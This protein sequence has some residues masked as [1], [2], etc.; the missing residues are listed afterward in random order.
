MKAIW[1]NQIIA[2]SND[3]NVQKTN[4]TGRIAFLKGVKIKE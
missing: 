4:I 1:N 2:E 3:T